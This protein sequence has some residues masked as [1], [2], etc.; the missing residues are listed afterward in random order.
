[1]LA[2]KLKLVRGCI[3]ACHSSSNES[4]REIFGDMGD[5]LWDKLVN[6]FDANE[7]SFI[8]Y[9]DNKNLTKLI[10]HVERHPENYG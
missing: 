7:A 1:M 5:Y 2:S 9:L 6:H 8:C 10:E 3:Q 4:F